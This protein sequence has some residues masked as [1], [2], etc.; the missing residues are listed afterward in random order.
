[1]LVCTKGGERRGGESEKG[2]I[3]S[4]RGNEK[5]ERERKN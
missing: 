3:G 2:R 4:T 1:M 5:T